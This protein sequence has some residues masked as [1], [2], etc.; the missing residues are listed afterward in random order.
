MVL[1]L[2]NNIIFPYINMQ[3]E[4]NNCQSINNEDKE[5]FK[6][7]EAKLISKITLKHTQKLTKEEQKH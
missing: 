2:G 5:D 6:C 7:E 3:I 4:H 1:S